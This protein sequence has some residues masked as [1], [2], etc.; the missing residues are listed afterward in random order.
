M[1]VLA[2]VEPFPLLQNIGKICGRREESGLAYD[3][4]S[5]FLFKKRSKENRHVIPG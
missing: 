4:A 5:L 2:F 3:F 1:N